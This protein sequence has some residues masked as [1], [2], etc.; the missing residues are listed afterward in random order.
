M[1]RL[2][3]LL[4]LVVGCSSAPTTRHQEVKPRYTICD[5]CDRS[6]DARIETE[7]GIVTVLPGET[8]LFKIDM[9]R[10][11]YTRSGGWYWW[12]G[13]STERSKVA[14]A[15]LIQVTRDSKSGIYWLVVPER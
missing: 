6:V 10:D 5:Y 11:E 13:N 15:K 2:L 3:L 1:S 4:I 8:K 12:C 7:T 14:G 9:K